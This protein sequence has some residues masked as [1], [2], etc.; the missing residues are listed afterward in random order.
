M[1]WLLGV[2]GFQGTV[3]AVGRFPFLAP[4]PCYSPT[5]IL[6][7]W[8]RCWKEEPASYCC[9]WL[10]LM[11]VQGDPWSC[12][13]PIP[14]SG[15]LEELSGEQAQPEIVAAAHRFLLPVPAH[16]QQGTP[17]VWTGQGAGAGRVGY[18]SNTQDSWSGGGDGGS[19][20]SKQVAPI[21]CLLPAWLPCSP[22]QPRGSNHALP[23]P[24]QFKW[25]CNIFPPCQ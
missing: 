21:C 5:F 24:P 17:V 22:S 9:H 15:C 6:S 10:Q 3:A 23:H 13:Y 2:P 12:S 19:S 14:T 25:W 20:G 7:S 4:Y 11:Q 16:N 18:P 8:K 1:L